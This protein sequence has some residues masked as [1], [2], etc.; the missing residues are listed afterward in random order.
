MF[1]RIFTVLF[2]DNVL[3]LWLSDDK[4]AGDQYNFQIIIYSEEVIDNILQIKNMAD[5]VIRGGLLSSVLHRN[6]AY[7]G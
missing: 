3:N 4:Q 6:N 1:M 5:D 7:T 2:L